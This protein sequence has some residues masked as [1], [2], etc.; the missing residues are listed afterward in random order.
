MA[1]REIELTA[2]RNRRARASRSTKYLIEKQR[3]E[4]TMKLLRALQL[5][6]RATNTP[7]ESTTAR[8]LARSLAARNATR[9]FASSLEH[10]CLTKEKKDE[11]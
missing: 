9:S 3:H 1:L 4:G 8:A 11:A 6:I 2:L 5:T 10:P 7:T